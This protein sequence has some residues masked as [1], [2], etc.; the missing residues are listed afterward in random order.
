[1]QIDI[2]IGSSSEGLT[3]AQKVNEYLSE[4]ANCTI[5]TDNFFTL[6]VSTFDNLCKKTLRYDFAILIGTKDDISKIRREKYQTI[7]DNVMF[8]YGLFT[9]SIGRQRTFILKETGAKLPSDLNGIT[10]PEFKNQVELKEICLNIINY[11]K[12]EIKLS[13]IS[14]LPSTAS[15]ITYYENFVKPVCYSIYQYSELVDTANNS[16]IQLSVDTLKLKIVLP[17][18]LQDDLKP[19][20]NNFIL[21]RKYSSGLIKGIHRLHSLYYKQQQN[22]LILIDIPANLNSSFK[23]IELF[24]GKDFIGNTDDFK[25]YMMKEIN[26][27]K[28]TLSSLL[29]TSEYTKQL[30]EV[31]HS[32]EV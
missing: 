24:L 10:L 1:M 26:N 15:A 2:F 19:Y 17:D 3:I 9:G 18:E 25:A 5:W 13:R 16:T 6:N 21:K 12:E 20:I 32:Y 11:I 27:F 23:A 30:S 4:I 22:D 28:M 8:E 29:S 31:V 7:R 14:M